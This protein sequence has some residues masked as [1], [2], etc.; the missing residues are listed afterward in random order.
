MRTHCYR[1][2]KVGHWARDCS[3]NETGDNGIRASL[4]PNQDVNTALSVANIFVDGTLIDTG[5]SQTIVNAD[6]YRFW[7]RKTVDVITIGGLS[8][9][10]CGVRM[11]TVS[12]EEGSPAKISVLVVRGRPLGFDLLLGI[13]AIKALRG[14]AVE[15][16]GQIQI[17][18]KRVA[19]L[20][21]ISKSDFIATFD[22]QS[23]AC[24]MEV[25]RGLH[26]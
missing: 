8:C 9:P 16:S 11:V 3:G 2:G 17:G 22:H 25:V 12:T 10:C 4:H 23:R 19:K 7:K 13:D 1:Y 6:Q 26:A 14:I 21:T 15:P 5:Y 18:D 20:I 24:G